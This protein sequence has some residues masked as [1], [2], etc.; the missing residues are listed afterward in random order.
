MTKPSISKAARVELAA[1]TANVLTGIAVLLL[2][3]RAARD[4]R[5]ASYEAR[6]VAALSGLAASAAVRLLAWPED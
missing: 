3:K 2:A 6:H 1:A 4:G 5:H